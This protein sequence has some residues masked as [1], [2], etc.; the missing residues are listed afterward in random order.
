MASN[1]TLIRAVK[2]ALIAAGSYGVAAV[3]QDAEIEQVVVTGTRITLPGVESAS[4]ITSVGAQEIALQQQPQIEKVIRTLPSVV[5]G[6]G[7][8]VNNG[9]SGVATVDLRGLGPQRNLL[10]MDGHRLV[11]YDINGIVD[12]QQIPT[13]M[14]ERIDVITGGASAVYGA[15]AI[16][17]VL[18]F[19]M[20]R[21]FEGVEANYTYST[22]GKGDADIDN[23]SFTIGSNVAE[24]RGNVVASVSWTERDGVQLGDRSLGKL[25]IATSDGSGYDDFKQ[26]N[27]LE[28]P[29]PNCGGPNT[30]PSS[31]PS[32]S[33]NTLPARLTIAGGPGLGQIRDDSTLG[34]NCNRFNFNPYNYYQTPVELFSGIALAHFEINEHAEPYARFIFQETSVTQQVAPSGLFNEPYWVPMFNPYLSS[35]AKDR[36]LTIANTGRVAGTVAESGIALPNWRD[37]NQNGVVDDPDELNIGI[38]RRT[39]ELGE[40]STSYN[41]STFQMLGGVRGA[42]VDDWRYDVSYSYGETNRT[43]RSQGYTNKANIQNALYADNKSTCL[44]GSLTCVPINLFGPYNSITPDMAQYASA[45]AFDQRLY[46]QLIVDGNIQGTWG[47]LPWADRPMAWL[48]GAGYRS[49]QGETIPDEC[50]KLAPTSCLGGAG[51]ILLPIKGEYNVQEYYTEAILPIFDGMTGAQMLDVELGYRW[52]DYNVTG[53]EST[54]KAGINWRPLDQLLVRAMYNVAS[55]APNVGE[56]FSPVQTGLDNAESDPCSETNAGNITPEL[57][58]L[59]VSTGMSQAQ[60]G[61][62]E[63]ITAGQSPAFFGTNQAALPGNETAD[64]FTAGIVWTPEFGGDTFRN[65]IIGVDYYDISIDD[66]ISNFTGQEVINGCYVAGDPTFCAKVQ[67]IGG[68]LALDGAGLQQYTENLVNQQVTGLEF[69]FAFGV[70]LGDYGDLAVSGNF[71]QYLTWERESSEL[72]PV[73]DCLGYYG[74]QCGNPVF[75]TRWIQRTTWN[76]GMFTASYLWRY[77]GGADIEPVQKAATFDKFQSID[78]YSYF[79]VF[80]GVTLWENINLS[81]GITNV[82]DKDPPVVGDTAASTDANSGNT[83]PS[84]YD[85]LGRVYTV[86]VNV[87]F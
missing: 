56:L 18:N 84:V 80:G 81:V 10:L 62:V 29:P 1:T 50:W 67:R 35:Q 45:V 28:P 37:N 14:I 25:P 55:R 68:T 83:F 11:P 7:Q 24:G 53:T 42:I 31:N 77:Y 54:W 71:N 9:T 66:Y 2:L 57:R 86:G 64:T 75:E 65:W 87:K 44:D 26:G 69:N 76:L 38:R 58:A 51:G 59:C 3:A 32:G 34:S 46:Q 16:S 36:I 61:T 78:S 49:E 13:A 6:D 48:V 43:N 4:P 85:V 12:T 23:I 41:S 60:V 27:G 73:L 8:N 63:D 79:D 30:F 74:N 22:T 17:G 39:P 20:K 47:Q 70:Q 33:A 19:V 5:P 52:S 40:R 15:D 82:F 72:L 21:D